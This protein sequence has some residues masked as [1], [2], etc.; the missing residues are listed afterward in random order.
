MNDLNPS[1]KPAA[2]RRTGV[3]LF[4]LVALITVLNWLSAG[5]APAQTFTTLHSFAGG[6][7]PYAGLV[8]SSNTL[9]GATYGT[10]DDGG[11]Y[12]TVFAVSTQGTG[13]TNLLTGGGGSLG[14]LILSGNTLY[15]TTPGDAQ[16]NSGAGTVFAINTDG[17]DFTNLHVFSLVPDYE[18]YVNADGA[19][20]RAGVILSGATLYGTAYFGGNT[21]DGTIFKVSTNGTGFTVLSNGGDP[22]AGLI[23]SGNTL[24]GTTT[25]GGSSG[26][27]SVFAISTN[28]GVLTNLHS[29]TALSTNS[30]GVYTNRDGASPQAGLILSGNTLYGTA[31]GGGTSGNGTVFAV[32]TSGTGFTNLH[33]FT[34]LSAPYYQSG[35]NSDGAIP[36]AGL[37]LSGNT[38]YGTAAYGGSSGHGTV[39]AVNTYG[40]GF[41]I[42]HNFTATQ[43]DSFGDYTNSDGAYPL[44]GLILSG[45]TLYGTAHYG[46]NLG[47]GTVFRL[48]FAPNLTIVPSGTNI[49]LT[50]PTNVAGFDYTGYTLQSAT[51]LGSPSVWST[52]SPAPVVIGGQN[53]IINPLTGAQQLYRLIL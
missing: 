46:G 38:L 17:T 18:P 50:W 52:N 14:G 24:Y 31:T 51:N 27:G 34:T 53:V 33:S 15:G 41:T 10:D 36:Q 32:N 37:I 45:N 26:R 42:L 6:G 43:A 13:F 47:Q 9:Y 11:G 20:P 49:I 29:F 25:S 48:S 23:L 28:G 8:L 40:M 21:G 22:Q 2:V 39:F 4:L 7:S 12:G 3:C 5:Q 16:P 30:S 1:R 44:A 35:T 19:E